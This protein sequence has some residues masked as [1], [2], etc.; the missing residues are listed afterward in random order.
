MLIFAGLVLVLIGV[1]V[2]LGDKLPIRLGRLPG[3][4]RWEGKNGAF[5]FPITTSILVSLVLTLVLW[6]MGRFR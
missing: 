6:L 3:D 4:I 5:Y 2:T 1:L